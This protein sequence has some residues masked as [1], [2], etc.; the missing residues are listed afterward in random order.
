[1]KNENDLK[2]DL[3]AILRGRLGGKYR[4]VPRFLVGWLQRTICQDRLNDFLARHGHKCDADFCHALVYD[5]LRITTDFVGE[6][7]LP[8]SSLRKVLFVSNHPLGGL[9]GMILIDYLQRRYGGKLGFVVN[10]LLMAVKPLRGVFL[11]INKH[12]KQ[13]KDSARAIDEFFESD[14]PMVMFPAGLCSRLDQNGDVRDLEWQKMFV[15]KARRSGRLIIP[16]HFCG[17]NSPFFYKF[18]RNRK[19]LG[20]K[21]NIEMIYLPR[22]VF[23]AEGKRFEIRFGKPIELSDF[24]ASMNSSQIAQAIKD[25]VYKL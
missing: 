24:N 22:E 4:F 10:D 23:M 21:F 12:G 8:P 16:I 20:L 9:D 14:N 18:A 25:E 2:I 11:P 6:E 7:N 19:R 1:M 17:E 5:E 15:G 13:S 3:D